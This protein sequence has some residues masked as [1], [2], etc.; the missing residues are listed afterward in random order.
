MPL[1][2][3]TTSVDIEKTIG[4]IEK[5]LAKAG[6]THI[7]KQFHDG[8]PVSV[9]FRLQLGKNN[10]AFK[11]PMREEKIVQVFKNAVSKRELPKR[12]WSD[13]DQARRTGWRIIKDWL[14]A[15]I[16]LLEIEMVK[17][18]EIFLPYMYDERQDKTF[19]EIMEQRN[20]N[21]TLEDQSKS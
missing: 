1:M 8:V 20:F 19:Y 11:L 13:Y 21:L 5:L 16:A 18:T 3:Y 6:A 10:I 17:P 4:E 15:Q 7:F 12:Y 14:S 9:A 2:K